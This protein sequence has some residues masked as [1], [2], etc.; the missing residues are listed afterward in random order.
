MGNTQVIVATV[1]VDDVSCASAIDRA[2][3]WR[4]TVILSCRF[5]PTELYLCGRPVGYY[6][7]NTSMLGKEQKNCIKQTMIKFTME[8]ITDFGIM[9]YHGILNLTGTERCQ[10]ASSLQLTRR[11]LLRSQYRTNN[12][13]LLIRLGIFQ[14]GY[15][16][17][18]F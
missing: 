11:N 2:V 3:H 10:M 18:G 16:V 9:I 8:I 7:I 14:F 6:R 4:H 15:F 17:C 1:V 5:S 13:D 12:C